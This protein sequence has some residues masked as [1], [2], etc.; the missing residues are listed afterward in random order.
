MAGVIPIPLAT[1]TRLSY[2]TAVAYGEAN[3]PE[4]QAGRRVGR[5]T[6]ACTRRV[7]SPLTAMHTHEWWGLLG[8]E[9]S[10]NACHSDGAIHGRHTST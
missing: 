8:C 7:Q 3:G 2:S 9:K 10:E 4:I 1:S 6:A 5:S